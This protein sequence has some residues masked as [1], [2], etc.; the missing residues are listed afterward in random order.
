MSKRASE[1]RCANKDCESHLGPGSSGY[2]T[3]CLMRLP[4]LQRFVIE[5]RMRE[6]AEQMERRPAVIAHFGN[7]GR[8][9]W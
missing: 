7:F 2:C 3:T 1:D 8:G 6:E 9:A 5:T 4:H